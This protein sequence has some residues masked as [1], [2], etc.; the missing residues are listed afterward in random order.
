MVMERMTDADERIDEHTTRRKIIDGD[1]VREHAME[2]YWR[3]KAIEDVLGDEYD[4][5]QLRILLDAHK[6]GRAPIFPCKQGDHVWINGIIGGECEEH[7][8]TSVSYYSGEKPS[9]W[10]NADLVGYQGEARCSFGYDQFGERVFTSPEAA[11]E[12]LGKEDD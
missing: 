1:K 9:M 10:F 11:R 6:A 5:A 3:L 8:I 4:L 7:V 12:A 2:I